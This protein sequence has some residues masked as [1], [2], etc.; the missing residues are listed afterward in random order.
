MET[1]S[2]GS[3]RLTMERAL[4]I[5][6]VVAMV[7]ALAAV[8]SGDADAVTWENE[9][10]VHGQA[11]SVD[12][13]MA[14]E[15]DNVYITYTRWIGVT[16][17]GFLKH[18]NGTAWTNE[19]PITGLQR[20]M[21]DS[22][23]AVSNGTA[24]IVFTDDTDGDDDVFYTSWDGRAWARAIPLSSPNPGVD[25]GEAAISADDQGVHVAWTG[26]LDGD[27]DIYYRSFDG[28]LW[29]N[30]VKVNIDVGS[31]DQYEVDVLAATGG[32]HF[33][34]SDYG[35]GDGDIKYR[36]FH[37]GRWGAV[38]E[39]S[40][41][42]GTELQSHPCL[43]VSDHGIH[44]VYSHHASG[45]SQTYMTT[46]S[47]SWDS[48]AYVGRSRFATDEYFPKVAGEGK[49]IVIAF[50]SINSGNI[51]F[52]HYVDDHWL[53]EE[54][55]ISP[56]P[57]GHLYNS[58]RI[59]LVRGVVHLTHTDTD[60]IG[61]TTRLV[62]MTAALDAM[63][64]NAWIEVL[65]PYWQS[66][67]RW[68]FDWYAGD[69]YGVTTVKFQ[70]RYSADNATWSRWTEI[71]SVDL[72]DIQGNGKLSFSPADG[73]G[74]YQFKAYAMDL[75]GKTEAPSMEPE[76]M[77][78]W[79]TGDPRG[80]IIIDEGAAYTNGT[81]VTLNLTY[82]D[83]IS[84][85]AMVRFGE[86][87]IGGDE[88]WENPV[89]TK[90]WTLP[91]VEGAHTVA[92]QVMDLSGRLSPVYTDTITL[93]LA[94]PYGTI[95]MTVTG[96]WTPTRA[97]TLEL[98]HGDTGS[99][100]SM[101]RFGDEAI[102]GDEP[103]ENP[104]DTRQWTLPEGEGTHTVAY[105]VMD[106]A[107]RTSEVYTVS[108]GL[109]SVAPTGSIIIGGLD[110]IVTDRTVTLTLT[111]EDG[112]SGVFGI[113]VSNE[114]I[115]GDEPWENPVEEL[116]WELSEGAGE[117]TVRYQVIDVA[118]H[119]SPVYTAT[120]T[121][122]L[123]DPTGAIALASGAAL[124]NTAT[125]TLDLTFEDLTSDIVG[126]RIQEEAI[127]GDE[128]WD[129]P[130]EAMEFQLSAG[131]G[132]KTIY[133]QVLDEAGRES[134]VYSVTFTLDSSNP[135]VVDTDPLPLTEKV[136]VDKV[137]S[138]RFSEIMNK[139]SVER[140]FTLSFLDGGVPNNVGGTFNWSSDG[141][142]V[143]FTPL[144]DLDKGTLYTIA[145]TDSALDAADN[146]LF[147]PLVSTFTTAGSGDGGEGDDGDGEG[148]GSLFLILMV[149]VILIVVLVAASMFYYV[150][151]EGKKEEE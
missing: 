61:R 30:S 71:H 93:D 146:S 72:N 56:V 73:D 34:W 76:A 3:F 147:P 62:H 67:S 125:V 45:Q 10:T 134:Q 18:Y 75:S 78:G 37:A 31:E 123:D 42:T 52:R 135:F 128:P 92:Y 39:V 132:E 104:V 108:V 109:D 129:D 6:F 53:M 12:N 23:V 131:D 118:G 136:P 148:L 84:G 74:H 101:V 119:T 70:Y 28:S 124:V 21:T 107:G 113:R 105:Q 35:D 142:T 55:V 114:A 60:I 80:S 51:V 87:A 36:V 143:T 121:L 13:D 8:I 130:V 95:T 144:G 22:K 103:W 111:A 54:N 149:A 112:T 24:H 20:S 85:V 64:P 1:R 126:I 47:G 17:Y 29:S 88:P 145:V 43:G 116:E 138:V 90:P 94:D 33:A 120:V 86:E 100:V 58:P 65:D 4:L 82:A 19:I 102:G 16:P 83:G 15:G 41:D 50:Q 68:S 150:R 77:N 122:D 46:F 44:V 140:A 89:D 25:S 110:S 99:G 139:D 66:T 133:F 27:S 115:G 38:T 7:L 40:S 81:S 127:G 106:A 49:H 98:S 57:S 32:V 11:S 2:E 69:D 151:L 48:P 59:A 9:Y 141:K 137:I 14:V 97:V 79:D 96:E 63:P 26:Y 91:D 117:K 5:A